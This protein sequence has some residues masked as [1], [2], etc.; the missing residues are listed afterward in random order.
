M[1]PDHYKAKKPRQRLSA[2]IDVYLKEEI[3]QEALV[4]NL[5]HFERFLEVAALTNGEMVNYNNV[6]LR[7]QRK[8]GQRIFLHPAGYVNRLYGTRLCQNRQASL[9]TST[10]LLLL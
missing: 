2:Y 5:S 10:A 9:D 3:L 6:R 7:H 8:H 1:I 4:R